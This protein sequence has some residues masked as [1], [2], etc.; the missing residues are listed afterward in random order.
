MELVNLVR[1][2]GTVALTLVGHNVH[3]HRPADA[4]GIAECFL[5]GLEI[6]TVD[7]PTIF[8][9]ER[10]EQRDRRDQLLE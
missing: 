5:D 6:V 3:D 7:R 8:E 4:R 1:N 9:A 2:C 10:L